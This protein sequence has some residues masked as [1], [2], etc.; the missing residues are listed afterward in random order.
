[1]GRVKQTME[2]ITS[3]KKRELCFQMRSKNMK[4]KAH[5]LSTLCGVKVGI[6][7]YRPEDST[8]F[9]EM[10]PKED[11]G[12][13]DDLISNYKNQDRKKRSFTVAHFLGE[14]KENADEFM[15]SEKGET[16]YPTW[17]SR[18]EEWSEQQLRDFAGFVDSKLQRAKEKVRHIDEGKQVISNHQPTPYE[19]MQMPVTMD[20]PTATDD[21]D[22]DVDLSY[23]MEELLKS[24]APLPFSSPVAI[25]SLMKVPTSTDEIKQ[26]MVMLPTPWCYSRITIPHPPPLL[27]PIPMPTMMIAPTSSS[28]R[29]IFEGHVND[30]PLSGPA[31]PIADYMMMEAPN[32][33]EL[34]GMMRC[35]MNQPIPS[36]NLFNL[37]NCC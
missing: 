10:W 16:R 12:A 23:L 7:M 13:L 8:T 24:E 14:K 26:L 28:S 9:S 3:Q 15:K 17:D 37:P 11:H 30:H 27:L 32:C 20:N 35:H 33:N 2:L 29:G 19:S 36:S 25:N 6:I 18:F 5:E 1:M 34:E 4:K 22:Q 21:Q 31:N